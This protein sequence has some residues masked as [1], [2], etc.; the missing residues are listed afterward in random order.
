MFQRI[1]ARIVTNC[2][3]FVNTFW[4]D[5]L[6][7]SEFFYGFQNTS[8]DFAGNPLENILKNLFLFHVIKDFMA[9]LVV[10]D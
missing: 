9:A 3:H 8:Q 2:N 7:N 1:H 6:G 5:F 10:Q 4:G